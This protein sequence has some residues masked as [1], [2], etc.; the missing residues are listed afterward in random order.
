EYTVEVTDNNGC[1]NTAK[2]TVVVNPDPICDTIGNDAPGIPDEINPDIPRQCISYDVNLSVTLDP[3]DTGIGVDSDYWYSWVGTLNTEGDATNLLNDSSIP[4]PT[5]NGEGVPEGVYTFVVTVTNKA[6]GC[7]TSCYTQFKM[8]DCTPNCETGFAVYTGEEDYTSSCFRNDG[9]KRW[10]W[11]NALNTADIGDEGIEYSLYAGAGRCDLS[12]GS[13]VGTVTVTYEDRGLGSRVYIAYDLDNG[14]TLSEAHVYV[15]CNPYPTKPNGDINDPEDYTVAPGQYTLNSNKL[16]GLLSDVGEVGF[17][18]SGDFYFIAHAV[19]CD[20]DIPDGCH[21][22]SAETGIFGETTVEHVGEDFDCSDDTGGWGKTAGDKVSFTAY[23]VPFENE[24]NVS[25]K[26][27]Y[28]TDVNINVYDIKG[29]LIRQVENTN[30][31]KGTIDK[32]TIDL[33]RTDNQMYFVRLTTSKGTLIKKI[34]STSNLSR[35]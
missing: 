3:A 25:Y 20:I 33:S 4:N 10:G 32:T 21:M 12:K 13:D 26:F 14:Y 35:E 30:Y 23:P 15:G 1:K 24:V 34:I 29:A 9:F 2:T 27:E 8:Y 16:E 19:V 31:I 18:A 7:M 5:F 22:D 17:K 6:T 11:T 28:D